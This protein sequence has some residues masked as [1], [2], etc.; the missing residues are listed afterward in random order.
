M[1]AAGVQER[2]GLWGVEG[3]LS[4]SGSSHRDLSGNEEG[5]HPGGGQGKA[6]G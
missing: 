5:G 2:E 6:W 3:A 4:W 1:S